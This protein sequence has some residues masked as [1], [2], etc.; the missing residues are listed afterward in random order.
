MKTIQQL[1]FL[2]VWVM[3]WCLL[4]DDATTDP[5]FKRVVS[6]LQPVLEKLDPKADLSYS[7]S[8]RTLQVAYK[9]RMYKIHGR[10]MTGEV[11]PKAHDEL[12]PSFQGFVLRVRLQ[13]KGEV[14]QAVTPQT[15]QKPY[16]RTDLDVTPLPGTQRQ[17][18]WSHSYGVRTDTDLLT[19][20]K[21]SL[22]DLKN[23]EP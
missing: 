23:T 22:R 18:F 14:N 5:E 6:A 13:Q 21:R 7:N 12:G 8:G 3:P 15:L 20:I 16:W 10:S 1:S 4:A 17:V 2:L 11:S 9:S 19:Q